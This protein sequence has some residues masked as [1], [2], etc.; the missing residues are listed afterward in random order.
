[1]YERGFKPWN[2]PRF[3]ATENHSIFSSI[4]GKEISFK[5]DLKLEFFLIVFINKS[6]NPSFLD[7]FNSKFHQFGTSNKFAYKNT[8]YYIIV[9]KKKSTTFL[10][11]LFYIII[12]YQK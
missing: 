2:L 12:S 3:T 4:T 6:K 11:F 8:G 7:K 9:D 5:T 10:K 1:M